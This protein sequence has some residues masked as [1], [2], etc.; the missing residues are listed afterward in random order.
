MESTPCM[1]CGK[2]HVF[3]PRT[4]LDSGGSIIKARDDLTT[5]V[6]V[7]CPH[8]Q[9]WRVVTIPDEAIDLPSEQHA[10]WPLPEP[11]HAA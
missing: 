11:A 1:R 8:C 9:A 2:A 5:G 10:N 3:D 7:K 4:V 6:V